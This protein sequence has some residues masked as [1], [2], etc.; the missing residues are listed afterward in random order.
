VDEGGWTV[1][2]SAASG[3]FVTDEQLLATPLPVLDD[4]SRQRS[5]A[6][7][8]LLARAIAQSHGGTLL[9]E[10]SAGETATIT[11]RLP[12]RGRRGLADAPQ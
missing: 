10:V 8:V 4:A 5:A 2:A 3:E 1:C 7:S 12:F 11:V 6:L 9:A